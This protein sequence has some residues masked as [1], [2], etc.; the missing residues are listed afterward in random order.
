MKYKLA[1]TKPELA[2]EIFS[3]EGTIHQEAIRQEA[4][5]TGQGARALSA[6]RANEL[7]KTERKKVL[8]D[9]DP[10][11]K[12][13]KKYKAV[14]DAGKWLSVKDKVL[15]EGLQQ[16]WATDARFRRI[17]EA[18]KAK[19]LILLYYTGPGSGSDLG[20]K[21]SADGTIDGDN[22][23]GKIIMRLAGYRSIM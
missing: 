3:Q 9:S 8:E 2:K 11:T 22:K 7:L 20:G 14:F 4:A 17:V 18:A 5:E 1:S 23:V 13:M 19:G 21:R 12:G 16:R 6:E 10:G 15:E